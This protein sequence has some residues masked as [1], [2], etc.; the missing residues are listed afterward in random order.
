M[1]YIIWLF[2]CALAASVSGAELDFNFGQFAEGSSPTNF[3]TA[4]LGGGAPGAWKIA[5]DAVPSAFVP[6]TDKAPGVTRQAVLAQTSKDAT[7][8]RFPMFVYDGDIFRNF[9][10]TTR[11]KIISGVTEQ[12]AGLIFRF[13]NISN[14]YVVRVSA[15][16]KNVRFY[17]VV[18]GVRSDPIGPELDLLPGTWH[19]LGVSCEGNHIN[20][21]L[22]D[23]PVM[24]ELGDPTFAEGKIGFWTKSDSVCYFADAKVVFT[25]RVPAAQQI[26]N[27][28]MERQPRILGLQIFALSTN[29]TTR[30]IA[31]KDLSEV[32]Q[33]GAEAELAA[34]RDGSIWFGREKGVV[35]VTLPMH[36]RNGEFIAAVHVKLRSFLG[37]TQNNAVNRATMILHTMEALGAAN[38]DLQD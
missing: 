14:F 38:G 20:V 34:I 15:L 30:I 23:K 4:L 16:G 24:P 22:D 17:K 31:S 37:E 33:A 7:D 18:N 1:R 2:A 10:F 5:L 28:V 9:K 3:H 11:F 26:V 8:E 32:G 13:Q 27:T 25:P 19:T 35:L 21:E 29:N 12:M 36:D 6:F